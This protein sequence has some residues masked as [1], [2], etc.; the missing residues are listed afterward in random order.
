ML[1]QE[2]I[3]YPKEIDDITANARSLFLEAEIAKG[4]TIE[5]LREHDTG[6]E[7]ILP[8]LERQMTFQNNPAAGHYWFPVIDGFDVPDD[9]IRVLIPS[10]I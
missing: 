2:R 1:N 8:L 4:K 6:R 7:F 9:G 5:E 10:H 3:Q